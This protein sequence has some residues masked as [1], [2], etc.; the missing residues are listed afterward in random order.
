MSIKFGSSQISLP[1]PK[2]PISA[3][4]PSTSHFGPL[5]FKL[6]GASGLAVPGDNAW[7]LGWGRE[8]RH[9]VVRYKRHDL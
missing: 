6:R 1:L 7:S 2:N 4:W 9:C 3:F 5:G 8:W